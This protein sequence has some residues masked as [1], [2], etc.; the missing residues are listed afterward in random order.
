MTLKRKGSRRVPLEK[1]AELAFAD[2]I[3]LMEDT[4]NKAESLLHKIEITTQNIGLFFNASK[5]KAMH[6]NLSLKSHIHAMN[7]DE[8]EKVDDFLYLGGYT[9]SSREIN[10][11]IGKSWGAL[12]SLEKIWN[13]HITTETKVRIF[14][15]TVE[16]ILLYG[17]ESWVMTNGAVKKVDGTYTCMLQSVKNIS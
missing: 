14:K 5:T 9:N 15:S 7:G 12:N 6:F 11:R 2:D 16:S 8:I 10:T 13:S 3:A 17:C 1:L 4:V